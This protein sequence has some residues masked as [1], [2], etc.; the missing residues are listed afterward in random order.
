MVDKSQLSRQ[1]DEEKSRNTSNI[2]VFTLTATGRRLAG[3]GAL[4]SGRWCVTWRA[5]RRRSVG[6]GATF[7]RR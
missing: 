1:L 4:I 6:V 3:D 2:Q 7:S 5:T